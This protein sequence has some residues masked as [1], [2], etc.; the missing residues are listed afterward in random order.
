MSGQG[1]GGNVI[2]AIC[3]FFYSRVRAFSTRANTWRTVLFYCGWSELCACRNRSIS[4][5]ILATW[6]YFAH[7]LYY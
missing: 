1:S 7:Y 6:R 4:N 2:A 5:C 3:N